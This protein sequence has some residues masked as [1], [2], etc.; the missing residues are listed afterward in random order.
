MKCLFICLIV[1][2]SVFQPVQAKAP[3][4]VGNYTSHMR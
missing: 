1:A 3:S 2:V 4:V